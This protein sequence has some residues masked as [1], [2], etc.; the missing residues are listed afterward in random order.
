MP[1]YLQSRSSS[2]RFSFNRRSGRNSH[3]YP[4]QADQYGRSSESLQYGSWYDDGGASGS[5]DED[6]AFNFFGL[7]EDG[8]TSGG[9]GADDNGSLQNVGTFIHT[10]K[11]ELLKKMVASER[12]N[13]T[14][15][16]SDVRQCSQALLFQEALNAA[17][18]DTVRA[19][20]DTSSVEI[21][22]SGMNQYRSS[23]LEEY[24]CL[25]QNLLRDTTSV[26]VAFASFQ[27]GKA[28]CEGS[29]SNINPGPKG[30]GNDPRLTRTANKYKPPLAIW[31]R[32]LSTHSHFRGL[33][34]GLILVSS[35][36]LAVQV[37]L[38]NDNWYTHRVLGFFD[39]FIL[40][41][42][43]CE[44][45][46][47]WLDSFQR[48]WYDTWNCFDF[49]ITALALLPEI[50][51]LFQ[52]DDLDSQ[53][54]LPKLARQLRVLRALRSFKMISKF[55]ALKVLIQTILETFASIWNIMLL[56]GIMMYIFAI[57][58][59]TLFEPY[60]ALG[61]IYY[62]KFGRL[63][64][65]CVSLFQLLTLDQWYNMYEEF[66]VSAP[67]GVVTLYIVS[68]VWL[69]GFVFRNIF[70]GVMVRG[71]DQASQEKKQST[72]GDMDEDS[73]GAVDQEHSSSSLNDE[74]ISRTCSPHVSKDQ[75]D[76]LRTQW[77]SGIDLAD[78][79]HNKEFGHMFAQNG[80]SGDGLVALK[81]L[82]GQGNAAA[83]SFGDV[84]W[85]RDALDAF[86]KE[87]VALQ[88]NIKEYEE[89]QRVATRII[90]EMSR[91]P[92]NQPA[93]KS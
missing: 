8:K 66:K 7:E 3:A 76:M 27:R 73:A 26:P 40:F 19:I 9:D 62:Q 92:A 6:D 38:P 52:G 79:D 60:S 59:V 83:S 33:I 90:I 45:V 28:Q 88:E 63:D 16:R 47:K 93:N 71:F 23:D 37:E 4:G 34:V 43:I 35:I 86:L 91:R 82:F 30:D 69:G 1:A 46:L 87:M 14:S 89:L 25:F 48:Y 53:A 57:A 49:F 2:Q 68:W 67:N 51:F 75:L 78:A 54:W 21:G 80:T 77:V 5:N 18:A 41:C 32:W 11:V 12:E 56:L 85:P 17:D 29:Q 65:A 10:A 15:L 70:V 20:T 81:H 42:F 22:S 39:N 61:T 74:P 55:G 31:A 13:L 64:Y 44:C 50:I 24:P 36:V 58:G 84:L 72:T